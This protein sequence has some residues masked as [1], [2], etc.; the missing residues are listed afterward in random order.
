M[1]KGE[2][3]VGMGEALGADAAARPWRGRRSFGMVG[4]ESGRGVGM[5]RGLAT[6]RSPLSS[7][8]VHDLDAGGERCE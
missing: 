3:G 7:E 2:P 6:V 8:G 4:R 1:K 5:S